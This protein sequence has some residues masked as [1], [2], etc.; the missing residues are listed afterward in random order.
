MNVEQVEVARDYIRDAGIRF[1][2]IQLAGLFSGLDFDRYTII[3]LIPQSQRSIVIIQKS[4]D[5]DDVHY[6]LQYKGAG[7]YFSTWEELR[8]YYENRF[9]DYRL[10]GEQF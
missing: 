4:K 9:H 3:K 2:P 7:R 6:C 10:R 5:P 1:S 8:R